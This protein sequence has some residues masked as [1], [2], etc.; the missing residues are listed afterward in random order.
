MAAM[1][2]LS[3]EMRRGGAST[4]AAPSVVAAGCRSGSMSKLSRAEEDAVVVDVD[5]K[6]IDDAASEGDGAAAEAT[7]SAAES[8]ATSSAAAS[9]RC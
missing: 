8:R 2:A 6:V 7:S 1:N 4:A 5:V 3:F 9:T